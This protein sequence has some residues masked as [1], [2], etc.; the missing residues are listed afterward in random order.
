[1]LSGPKKR[2][3][4]LGFTAGVFGKTPAEQ[5]AKPII[6]LLKPRAY[7]G[8]PLGSIE[9]VKLLNEANHA[10]ETAIQENY[11]QDGN[12]GAAQWLEHIDPHIRRRGPISNRLPVS[13]EEAL[14][15]LKKARLEK[16][17]E[18]DVGLEKRH[19]EMKEAIRE[20]VQRENTR[21]SRE[22]RMRKEA[23]FRAANAQVN[24]AANNNGPRRARVGRANAG[25]QA[26]AAAANGQPAGF[27]IHQQSLTA[28]PGVTVNRNLQFSTPSPNRAGPTTQRPRAPSSRPSLESKYGP[29]PEPPEPH[30]PIP[31]YPPPPPPII[32]HGRIVQS[33]AGSIPPPPPIPPAPPFIPPAPPIPGFTRS[34]PVARERATRASVAEHKGQLFEH[35]A[36]LLRDMAGFA[37]PSQGPTLLEEIAGFTRNRLRKKEDITPRRERRPPLNSN[38]SLFDRM[39]QE[40]NRRRKTTKGGGLISEARLRQIVQG[41]MRSGNNSK[42]LRKIV[43]RRKKT[44]QGE[45]Q[46]RR[47]ERV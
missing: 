18:R 8:L 13:S 40:M 30:T 39:Q 23:A 31:N 14:Y 44:Y 32:R 19:R 7:V 12:P 5:L 46:E 25:A 28:N 36:S 3:Y 37:N 45:A 27:T 29:A 26:A 16:Q 24:R 20:E 41:E 11:Y 15:A 17:A 38:P 34:T 43:K 47:L 4:G 42:V 22:D 6:K 9:N 10:A 35:G 2:K 33:P 1:M 21:L